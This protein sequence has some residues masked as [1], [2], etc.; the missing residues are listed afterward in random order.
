MTPVNSVIERL[1]QAITIELSKLDEYQET[2]EILELQSILQ[3]M[4]LEL[5]DIALRF[6]FNQ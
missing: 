2:P 5:N 1:E 3:E 4:L 6:E